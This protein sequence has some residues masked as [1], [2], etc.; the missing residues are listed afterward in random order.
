MPS[1]QSDGC[2]DEGDMAFLPLFFFVCFRMSVSLDSN[3]LLPG[4]S[5]SGVIYCCIE[6]DVALLLN[7]SI[8]CRDSRSNLVD[9]SLLMDGNALLPFF[10]FIV[11]FNAGI[12]NPPLTQSVDVDVRLTLCFDLVGSVGLIFVGVLSKFSVCLL[13]M[14]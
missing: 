3:A 5:S 7:F 9:V 14:M 4:C 10:F 13:L 1:T 11:A 8:F 2:C 12:I 6:G